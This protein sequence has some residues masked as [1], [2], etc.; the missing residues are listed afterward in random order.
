MKNDCMV[1]KS[2]R[3]A[4]RRGKSPE[5]QIWVFQGLGKRILCFDPCRTPCLFQSIENF[6][7]LVSAQGVYL[8]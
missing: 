3:A 7:S 4:E 1:M 5:S 8:F 2:A 6:C